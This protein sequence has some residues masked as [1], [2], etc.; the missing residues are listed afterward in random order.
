MK[1]FVALIALFFLSNCSFDNKSGIWKSENFNAKKDK[2]VF[3]EFK[4]LSTS[5]KEFEK[6]I[7][8]NQNYKFDLPKKIKNYE[9]VDVFYSKNNNLENFHYNNRDKILF[10]SKKISKFKVNRSFLY[11]E[12]DIFISDSKGNIIVYSINDKKITRKFN[13]YKKKYKKFFK[14]LNFILEEDLIYISDNFGYLYAFDYKQNKVI[15]AKNYKIPF[16]SNLKIYKNKLILANQ[17]NTLFF[18]N[19]DNGEIIKSFPTEETIIKNNFINNIALNDQNLFFINTY[20]TLYSLNNQNMNINWFL[21]LNQS[22]DLNPSN[23]FEG[24]QIVNA[25]SKLIVSSKD[26][27]YVMDENTGSIIFKKNIPSLMRPIV[28]KNNLFLI[29]KKNFFICFDL[30]T[31]KFIYSYNINQKIADFVNSKKK[32]AS[33]KTFLIINDK[34]KIF[35]NNSFYLDFDING[36]LKKIDKLQNKMYSNP[37]IIDSS[38]LYLNNKNKLLIVD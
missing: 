9:W 12:K 38:I 17:A 23:A 6:I 14:D 2:N 27:L 22:S 15:W 37:I 5:I 16:R 34:I 33:L 7:H 35:L 24:T 36:S 25:G 20:G 11:K 26:Y 18:I 10:K 21:N 13:F 8:L 19:K 28:L 31:G 30:N 1:L 4:P 32:I 3:S 29:T